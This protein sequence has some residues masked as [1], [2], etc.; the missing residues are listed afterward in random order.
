MGVSQAVMALAAVMMGVVALISI[1]KRCKQY[2]EVRKDIATACTSRQQHHLRS[3]RPAFRVGEYEAYITT[4]AAY[5]SVSATVTR[6]PHA[7]AILLHRHNHKIQYNSTVS[8]K[9]VV[10]VALF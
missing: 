1:R 7:K 6:A 5:S 8:T 9:A 10:V 2:S 3:L 4:G